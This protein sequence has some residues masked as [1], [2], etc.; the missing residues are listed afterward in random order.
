MTDKDY[1]QLLL[2][3]SD[4]RHIMKEILES[5]EK[6]HRTNMELLEELKNNKL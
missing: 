6:W 3:A 2:I 5:L 4:Q 1:K